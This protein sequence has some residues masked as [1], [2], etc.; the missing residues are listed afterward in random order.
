MSL[1]IASF[2]VENLFSR[3]K[4]LNLRDHTVAEDALQ[5]IDALDKLLRR[6]TYA[7]ADKKKILAL[8]EKLGGY[9][10]I[11]EDRGKLFAGRG[12]Q[13]RV[14]A[15]GSGDWDG[16]IE[17]KRAK[18][19][20]M[21]R[22][23]T[24]KVIKALKADILCVVEAED[25]P[26]LKSFNSELLDTKK[27]AQ[28][29]LIDG[30]DNRGIDVGVMTQHSIAGIR[31]HVYDEDDKGSVFSRD[32]LEVDIETDSGA[33]VHLLCNHLKS[34]GYGDQESNDARRKR[35]AVRLAKILA[36]YNLKK[37]F[38]VVAGDLNDTP[39][40][41][42][43]S[44]LVKVPHLHDVLE[45]KFGNDIASRWTYSYRGTKNQIDYLLVSAALNSR[46]ADAG[47]FRKGI[48]NLSKLTDGAESS[49]KEIEKPSDAASDHGAPWAEFDV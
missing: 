36:G 47:V 20:D 24:A 12:A 29:M 41:K 30:N 26:T 2:N 27:F 25:R 43:L 8:V 1:R 16:A 37:D 5:D 6:K 44:P 15:A 38:V 34:K 17:F 46:F 22:R 28:V 11:R 48:Y 4:V 19:S 39:D 21:A 35:Q 14:S 10:E 40:S 45:T 13:R 42:P 3:A 31:S 33:V 9:I 49:F 7:A 32:C 23:S 18:F